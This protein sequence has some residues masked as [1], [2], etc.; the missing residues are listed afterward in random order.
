MPEEDTTIR[1]SREEKQTLD[2]ARNAWEKQVGRRVTAGEFV[3]FLSERYL[4]EVG[5]EVKVTK[6]I[7]TS[8]LIAVQQLKPAEPQ[9][10][11]PGPQ[12]S[13]VACARCGGQIG[14]RT[15]VSSEGYCPYCGIYLRLRG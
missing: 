4:R 6:P 8:G 2:M 9:S 7:R 1:I 15:D 11:S 10:V 5:G 14:W 3:R 13:L 12:V